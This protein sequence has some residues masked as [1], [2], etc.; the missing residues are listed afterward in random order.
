MFIEL[1]RKIWWSWQNGCHVIMPRGCMFMT[2]RPQRDQNATILCCILKL[3]CIL[4]GIVGLS[5]HIK[6]TLSIKGLSITQTFDHDL[7]IDAT[8]RTI[9]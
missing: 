2:I 4:L 8:I 9:K 7:H 6:Y 1:R 5:K 3:C